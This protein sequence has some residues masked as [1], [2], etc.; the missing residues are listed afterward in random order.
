MDCGSCGS[1]NAPGQKF[2]GQCGSRLA[3]TCADCGAANL[4]TNKFCGECGL[5]LTGQPS[6]SAT[7]LAPAPGGDAEP[8]LERRLVS[9]LFA[10]LVGFTPFSESRDPEEVRGFLTRYFDAATEVIERFGGMVEKFIGDAVMAVWGAVA[11]SEDDAERAVRAGL[12]LAEAV[13]KLGA[14]AGVAELT[15]RVGVLTGEASVGSG[16]NDRGLVIGDMVNTASR[17][18]SVAPPGGVVVGE[19]TYRLTEHAIAFEPLGEQDLK[20][21]SLPVPAWRALHVVGMRGG[22]RRSEGLEA[23]FVGRDEE[24][25]L[26]KEQLH[27]TGREG[28]SRLVS[29]TGIG[30][31]GKSRLVWEFLKYVDGLVEPVYWHDGRSPSYGD[32]VAF[33]ALAEMVRGRARIAETDDPETTGA[34]L[35]EMLETYI[36]DEQER[37]WLEP[38]LGGLLGLHGMP[39]GERG[40]MFSAFRRL[41]ERISEHGTTALVFEDLHWADAGLLDFVEE[42]TE[43]SRD[44]PILV[45]TLAR[46]ELLDRR[47]TWGGGRRNFMSVFLGPLSDDAMHDLVTG[48]VPGI[49][50]EASRL[51]E[52]RAAGIPLYA[53]E[54]VRMLLLEERLV[55][56]DDG[57]PHLV[58]DLADL[59]VPDSLHAVIGARLDRLDAEDR[60]LLQDSAVLGQSFT[61]ETLGALTGIEATELTDRLTGLVRKELLTFDVDPRSPERGQYAFVQS[62]IREVAYSRLSRQDRRTRHLEIARHFEAMG[63]IELGGIVADHYLNALQAS[64]DDADSEGLKDRTL[65]ALREAADRAAALHSHEQVLAYSEQALDLVL[66]TDEQPKWLERAANSARA[67]VRLEIAEGYAKRLV[68]W[69]TEHG[70]RSGYLSAKLLTALVHIERHDADRALDILAPIVAEIGE[71]ADDPDTVAVIALYARVRMLRGEVDEAIDA[72]ERALVGAEHLDH[73]PVIADAL[74]TRGTV[75]GDRG[76]LREGVGL[77]KAA[78]EIARSEDLPHV[79]LRASNNLAYLLFAEDPVTTQD[80]LRAAIEQARR[81]GDRGWVIQLTQFH[82]GSLGLT[83]EWD[84]ALGIVAELKDGELPESEVTGLIIMEAMIAAFR[85]HADLAAEKL[86]VAAPVA[87][88]QTDVQRRTFW[89]LDQTWVALAAGDMDRAHELSQRALEVDSFGHPGVY[90]GIALTALVSGV[91]ERLVA[92]RD[93]I[94]AL[95]RQVR[96]VKGA[97]SALSSVLAALDGDESG[98]SDRLELTRRHWSVFPVDLGIFLVAFGRLAAGRHPEAAGATA[99]GQGILTR[100]GAHAFLDGDSEATALAESPI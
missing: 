73:L 21:K 79:E 67:L 75:L 38:R 2:C 37:A 90:R 55:A 12:E 7:P 10:D 11:A 51:V 54:L 92:A 66:N 97:H 86:V 52:D 22:D 32:G 6:E 42:L 76:R 16:A 93:A 29:I 62:L 24:L 82:L 59:A 85:G 58:G 8:V 46:P 70:D 100:T 15:V 25:R 19:S 1:E 43:W 87:E 14:D 36:A 56:D 40:E 53:V 48:L 74:T 94:E 31:I 20:G 61:A 69:Q 65:A 47:P 81:I 13:G 35:G 26:L 91:P 88:R 50:D 3:L 96:F 80:I 17:L 23:P 60:A 49:P 77:L 95:P 72:S 68:A 64:P 44:K 27:A 4:P 34:K 99:E 98:A 18:Q 28:R 45:V 84:E 63:D 71:T 5:P 41:F 33:W 30:G 78:I 57:T 89:L 83:G 39:S 9:V